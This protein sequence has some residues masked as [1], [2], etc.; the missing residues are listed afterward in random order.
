MNTLDKLEAAEIK[1]QLRRAANGGSGRTIDLTLPENAYSVWFENGP[2]G[3]MCNGTGATLEEAWRLIG[4]Y[5]R[6][7]SVILDVSEGGERIIVLK[8]AEG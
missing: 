2:Q 4:Q 3:Y 6:G 5:H 7:Y 8:S 1:R